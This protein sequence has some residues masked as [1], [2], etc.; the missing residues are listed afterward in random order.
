MPPVPK[1]ASTRRG[2]RSHSPRRVLA[3]VKNPKIPELPGY[4][5]WHPAVLEFWSSAWSSPM[6]AEWDESDRHT[7]LLA[8]RALQMAWDAES[9][10]T[11]RTNAMAELRLILRELGLTPMS[12]RTLQIEFERADEAA[13]R[14]AQRRAT[15]AKVKRTPDPRLSVV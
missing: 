15:T 4:C 5:D 10:P 1:P 2:H 9:R 3:V 7:V 12:R 14:G 11:A 13:H 8:A 6:P